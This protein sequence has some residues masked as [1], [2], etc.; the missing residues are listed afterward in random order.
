MLQNLPILLFGISPIFFL[1][2]SFICFSEYAL[3][4]YFVFLFFV[5]RSSS[6]N[7][8]GVNGELSLQ[9]QHTNHINSLK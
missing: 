6:Y 8:Y 9:L 3:C 7:M 2:C 5:Q 1:L 4:F